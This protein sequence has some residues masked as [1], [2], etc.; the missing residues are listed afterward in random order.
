ML[1]NILCALAVTWIG[2]VWAGPYDPIITKAWIGESV[3]GQAT[4]TLQLNI[5][6]VKAVSLQS[7]TSPA[8]ES[9]EIHNLIRQKDSMKVQVI[10][11]LAL[12]DHSTTQ[13]GT[14]G[15]FLMMKGL[16]QPLKIGDR[17]PL[18]MAF[19]FADKKTKIIEA[20]AEVKKMD[21]SYK[22]FGT[23]GIYD[24]SP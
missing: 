21:L 14:R 8:A 2:N 22:Q 19:T 9:V 4:A 10:P 1:R 15:L 20:V 6:T 23:K 24:N 3:P 5:S 12:P 17:I 16:K 18:S 13:I 7:V 11:S